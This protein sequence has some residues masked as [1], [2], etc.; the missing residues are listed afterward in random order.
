MAP[1]D[2]TPFGFTP[3]EGLVYEVLLREGPGTGYAVAR[4][5]G[6]ARANAYAA[7]EGLTAKGAAQATEA[8]PRR[9]RPEPPDLLLALIMDRQ[10]EAVE[11]LG[12]ALV[13]AA[14]PPSSTLVEVHTVRSAVQILGHE[15]A[16][17]RE[18]VSLFLPADLYPFLVPMLRKAA[19]GGVRLRLASSSPVRIDPAPIEVDTWRAWPGV[20]LLALVD[21]RMA[22]L[23]TEE[24]PDGTVTGHWGAAPALVAGVARLLSGIGAHP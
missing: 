18:E 20:P 17:A 15:I 3:T 13:E 10:G 7:L 6:L 11:R 12:V 23:G 9:Y 2:L 21:G 4:A 24:G 19:A 14:A 22:L 8:R 16:R 1:V 5:A